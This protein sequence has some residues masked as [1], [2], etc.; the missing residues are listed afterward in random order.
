MTSRARSTISLACLGLLAAID[1][2]PAADC[3]SN[4]V[5][6][7]T[8]VSTGASPDCNS[9]G[10]PDECEVLPGI[11]F[12][13]PR[14]FSVGVAPHVIV[15][16]D[17]DRD[18]D[19][20]LVTSDRADDALSVLLNDGR[21][22]FSPPI[23][24]P[25][26][27]QPRGIAAGD[28]DGD[29]DLDVVSGNGD[30]DGLADLPTS[31]VLLNAGDGSFAPRVD[32]RA[33]EAQASALRSVNLADIDGDN[34]LD[35]VNGFSDGALAGTPGGAISLLLGDGRGAFSKPVAITAAVPGFEGLLS[36][37]YLAVGPLDDDPLPEILTVSGQVFRNLGGGTFASPEAFTRLE[38]M[39]GLTLLDE[40]RDGDLD[41]AYIRIPP[42]SLGQ[43]GEVVF[44]RNDRGVLQ[45]GQDPVPVPGLPQA[46]IAAAELDGDGNLD[47]AVLLVEGAIRVVRRDK[48][49]GFVVEPEAFPLEAGLPRWLTAADLNG[50]GKSDLAIPKMNDFV[51]VLLNTTSRDEDSNGVPDEC[52]PRFF[53]GD[54]DGDGALNLTDS[55]RLLLGLF[56]GAAAPGC[57]ESA[58]SNDDGEL[59]LT[60]AVQV[61][62]YLFQAGPP[63]AAPGPPG[64]SC[65][66]GNGDSPFLG[67]DGYGGCP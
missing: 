2:A 64:D 51:S 25:V 1:L 40:D 24:L 21:G 60:D 5:D 57:R 42:E 58:D 27:D 54:V 38:G 43:D 44:F 37:K 48:T 17:L 20:D 14:H 10:V 15:S 36:A 59:N 12:T 30:E 39:L 45:P 41:A 47:I 52:A 16:A 18:G 61:L 28:L 6:D 66:A 56:Q 23:T 62:R 55:V 26:G 65:I 4:G 3:N 7:G 49:D 13:T 46:V 11:H 32:Y 53:R 9:N 50:D 34:D 67:C 33:L 22:S 19:R 63:P 35:I 29:D 31:S 8:D